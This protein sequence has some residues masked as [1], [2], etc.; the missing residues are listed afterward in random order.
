MVNI[1]DVR[2]SNSSLKSGPPGMVALFV[3]ATR[4]IGEA[5]LKQFAKYSNAPTVY[6]VGR[7][8]TSASHL[9]KELQT[10]NPQG[11]FNFIQSEI[12]LIRNVDA[13]CDEIKAKEKKMDILFLSPG[14][15]TFAGRQGRWNV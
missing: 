12:S 8:K 2:L 11:T 10:L 13:V 14:F 15:L 3:G 9:L 7:S 1:K 5:T 6:V 4:G